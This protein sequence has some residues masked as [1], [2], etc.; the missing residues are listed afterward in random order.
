MARTLAPV[1]PL[2]EAQDCISAMQNVLSLVYLLFALGAVRVAQAYDNS[3]SDNV[4]I[5]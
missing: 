1:P 4:S 2:P 3:R 5:L